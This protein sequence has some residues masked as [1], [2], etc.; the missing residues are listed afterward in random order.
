ME[1]PAAI[2]HA[3]LFPL[4]DLF[5][6][7][8]GHPTRRIEVEGVSVILPSVLSIGLVFPERLDELRLEH[9]VDAMR[10]ALRMEQ[11]ER[12]IWCVP[13][14]SAPDGLAQ[15][16]LALGMRPSDMP[17]REARDAQMAC[18]EAPPPATTDLVVRPAETFDEFRAALL[19]GTDAF[20]MDD[21]ARK[22]FEDSAERI[23]AFHSD[24]GSVET[25]VALADGVVVAFGGARYGRTAVYLAGGGT[26]PDHRGRG[27]YRALVRARWE[28]A[29]ARGTPALTVGAGA[30]SRPIL[31]RLGF[32]I[33][34]WADSLLDPLD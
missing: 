13:E 17:G 7:P 5:D 10:R 34:G 26:H 2:R 19:V 11:R 32:S 24:P 20:A 30:M 12:A 18:V 31:E 28:A 21:E 15:R 27:A 4:S 29:A 8:P 3:A 23:W 6:F 33:V 14:A 25:F 16:L 1:L 22:S 9:L